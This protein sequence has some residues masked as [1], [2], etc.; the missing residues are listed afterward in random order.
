LY[1]VY[2]SYF[3]LDYLFQNRSLLFIR[4]LN[5][6]SCPRVNFLLLTIACGLVSKCNLPNHVVLKTVQV[7]H[8]LYFHDHEFN[9]PIVIW[10]LLMV[11]G[12]LPL[13]KRVANLQIQ[14]VLISSNYVLLDGIYKPSDLAW[15]GTHLMIWW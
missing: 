2:M 8:S 4:F 10:G 1:N 12:F 13:N 3:Q 9:F 5:K 15:P 14:W 6:I 11:L 7:F